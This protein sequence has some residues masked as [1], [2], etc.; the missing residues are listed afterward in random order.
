M[1]QLIQS[2]KDGQ[3][4]VVQAPTPLSKDGYILIS[5]SCSAI[6]SGTEKMLLDFGKS[7]LINKALS[8]PDKVAE[9]LKKISTEGLTST[10]SAINSK[11]NSPISL[12][13][14]NVGTVIEKGSDIHDFK[15]GDRVVSNGNH[16]EQVLVPRNLCCK[17]PNSVSDEEASFAVIGS[18]GLQGIRMANPN[19]G[20]RYLVIGLGIIGQITL[21]LLKS[22]GCEVFAF[23]TNSQ[24]CDL[25]SQFGATCLHLNS[26]VNPITWS[27]KQTNNLGFDGVIVTASTNTSDPLTLA[28][29]VA[30]K[31]GKIV[32][33][34]TSKIELNRDTFYEK[35]L[36]FQ[37][38]KSYGPGRYDSGYEDEGNDYPIQYVR[39]TENRNIESVLRALE[40]GYLNV[41]PL[42]SDMF[43]FD[44]ILMAY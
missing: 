39:W 12:G 27:E 8:Q 2:L 16:A 38:S 4:D 29:N 9:A 40:L 42:I 44:N 31:K 15:I 37:V 21:Q 7:N 1:R 34:G 6:S 36:S 43:E 11:L 17:I 26:Y 18:I 35:E 41:K 25:A 22:N 32:L 30:R 23:D 13:Y 3:V 20:E 33:V 10:V 19:F 28:A 14:S 5:T 24:R